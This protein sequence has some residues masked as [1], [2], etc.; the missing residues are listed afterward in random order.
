M[1]ANQYL[2]EENPVVVMNI[3][4]F[5]KLEIELFPEVAPNTVN[6][7]IDLVIRNFYSGLTFHR[8]IFGFMIQGGGSKEKSLPIK[9]E[10]TTNGFKNFLKHTR[11]VISMARTNDPN[12]QTSQF[13]IMHQDSPHLDG[14]YTAF[15]TLISGIEIVDKIV[16]QKKDFKDQPLEDIVIESAYVNLKGIDYPKP[17]YYKIN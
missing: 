5:G 2:K 13:F 11:G 6:N 10:F 16:S 7:F 9:G 1:H 15:G 12:S 17:T 14:Q 4:N 3:K 8:I